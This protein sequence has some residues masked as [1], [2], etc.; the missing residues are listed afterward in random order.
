MTTGYAEAAEQDRHDADELYAVLEREVVPAFYDR[1]AAGVPRAW[2]AR[3][4][5]SMA[6]LTL[7]YGASRMVR[8]YL[9]KA[10]LP[11]AQALRER[12]ADGA[13]AAKAMAAWDRH[14]H[15]AW[16]GVHIG[17]PDFTRQD[18]GW[19]VSV[20][21]YL[22]EIAAADVRVE[23]YADPTGGARRRGHR[24][25]ARRT[26]PWG[27]RRLCLSRPGS[28]A[29]GRRRITPCASCRRHHRRTGAGGDGADT[30]AEVMQRRRLVR[31]FL[32]KLVT[33]G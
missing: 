11:A 10:Y 13:A 7:H 29:R 28:L 8:E 14:L 24:S 6:D 26:D 31:Q 19:E 21:V 23:G 27:N 15:R 1:D 16:P 18:D 32:G 9:D 22:G 5:R 4:R 3:M 25:V 30:L 17:E 20:P 33:D 12:V 2:V